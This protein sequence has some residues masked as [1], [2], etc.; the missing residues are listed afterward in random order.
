MASL[1]TIRDVIGEGNF[2][3]NELQL[4]RWT[5]LTRVISADFRIAEILEIL[6]SSGS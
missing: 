2:G 3:F 6:K 4:A 5:I 1:A